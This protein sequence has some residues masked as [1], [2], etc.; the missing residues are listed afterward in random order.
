MG[1]NQWMVMDPLPPETEFLLRST[2]VE[3]REAIS[4]DPEKVLAFASAVIRQN[5]ERGR[6][7]DRAM[8]RI[9]ELEMREAIGQ[10]GDL[11]EWR[12]VAR[13]LQPVPWWVAPL[14]ALRP[15]ALFGRR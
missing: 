1:L 6:L 12:K 7:L 3:M 11:K 14:W 4:K 2:E 5:T 9:A 10:G 8:R 15:W 13:K